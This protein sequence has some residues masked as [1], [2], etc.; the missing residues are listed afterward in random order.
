ML[1]KIFDYEKWTDLLVKWIIVSDTAFTEVERPEFVELLQHT[2]NGVE[3][4]RVPSAGTV[5]N[6]TL[7]LSEKTTQDL[8]QLFAVSCY[9]E[10]N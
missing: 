9:F 7:Q 10:N 8:K 4:L 6:C 1:Q 5:K 3:S 2:Y